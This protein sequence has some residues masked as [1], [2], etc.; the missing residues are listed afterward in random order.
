MQADH[1]LGQVCTP[2]YQ[3]LPD[4]QQI[5]FQLS[6]VS[7]F[8]FIRFKYLPVVNDSVYKLNNNTNRDQRHM[9]LHL[10]ILL[11][12]Y[13]LLEWISTLYTEVL[14]SSPVCISFY[15]TTWPDFRDINPY[16]KKLIW[17][18][19]KHSPVNLPNQ[20]TDF[21]QNLCW[22]RSLLSTSC[23]IHTTASKVSTPELLT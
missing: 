11:R 12:T 13:M 9:F 21:D 8:L 6:S 4:R 20:W 7:L 14:H 2:S 18:T 5:K 17:W 22:S 1:F 19:Q 15:Q 10:R 16:T 3:K 23:D